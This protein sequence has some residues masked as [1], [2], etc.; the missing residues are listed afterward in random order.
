MRRYL[1][2]TMKR[3]ITTLPW[4]DMSILLST[5]WPLPYHEEISQFYYEK[6]DHYLTMRRH[7]NST[8][9]RMT[10]TFPSAVM[11]AELSTMRRDTWMSI[12]ST[13]RR[14]PLCTSKVSPL[15]TIPSPLLSISNTPPPSTLTLVKVIS[16]FRFTVLLPKGLPDSGIRL[17]IHTLINQQPK[18]NPIDHKLYIAVSITKIYNVHE[19]IA[20]CLGISLHS[21]SF[22]KPPHWLVDPLLDDD[23]SSRSD[24]EVLYPGQCAL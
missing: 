8:V 24:D 21:N 9:N 5:E 2:S 20:N 18:N 10:T 16:F 17:Y 13:V 23:P 11:W 4:G 14:P 3:M 12:L 22:I 19:N 7:V 15:S 1:N 6:N